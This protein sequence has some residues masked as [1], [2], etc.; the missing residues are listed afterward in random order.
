MTF[1]EMI[2]TRLETRDGFHV[3]IGAVPPEAEDSLRA[4]CQ[5]A[6]IDP[7]RFIN[8]PFVDD[9]AQALATLACDL[10]IVSFP[11]GGGK[12]ILEAM[13]AGVGVLCYGRPNLQLLCGIDIAYSEALV[14]RTKPEFELILKRYDD[15]TREAHRAFARDYFTKHH[16]FPIMATQWSSLLDRDGDALV[17]PSIKPFRGSPLA[18]FDFPDVPSETIRSVG[19]DIAVRSDVL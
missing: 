18:G 6:G 9:V 5:A 3:H 13:A 17:P 10:Y 11:V 16:S 8:I 2:V 7:T 14:W 1:E 12:A 4:R 15:D 19:L